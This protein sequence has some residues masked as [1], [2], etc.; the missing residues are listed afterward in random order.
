M[1]CVSVVWRL[2]CVDGGQITKLLAQEPH[3]RLT[4]ADAL[5]HSFIRQDDS[6]LPSPRIIIDQVPAVHSHPSIIRSQRWETRAHT[7]KKQ[8]VLLDKPT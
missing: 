4:A 5:H 8:R 7:Q 3:V 6:T 2:R 1:Q